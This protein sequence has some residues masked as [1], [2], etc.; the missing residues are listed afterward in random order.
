VATIEEAR[1]RITERV[2]NLPGVSGTAL[3]LKGG[4][5]CITVY[6]SQRG[7]GVEAQLPT[8]EGGFPVVVEHTGTIRRFYST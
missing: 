4:K 6:L 5:P 7:T 3:G 8:T 2:I 1:A